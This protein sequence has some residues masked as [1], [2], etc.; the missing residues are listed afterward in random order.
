MSDSVLVAGGA[1]AIVGLFALMVWASNAEREA[2]EALGGRILSR[3]SSGVGV[4]FTSG[5]NVAV[6]PT[7]NTVTF[8][9]SPDGRI[10]N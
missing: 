8:C 6:V 5:G 7:T 9:V 10:L 3:T 4:G 2:C 1:V